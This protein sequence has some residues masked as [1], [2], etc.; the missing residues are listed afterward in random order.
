MRKNGVNRELRVIAGGVCAP[1][2]FKAGGIACGIKA[3]GDKDLALI[4]AER[5]CPTACV[6]TTSS[7]CGAPVTISKRHV[8]KGYARAV[9]AN[10]G[11]ANVFLENGEKI[12]DYACGLV[13]KH[14]GVLKE[15]V[16]I[17]STGEVG[18]SLSFE[19]FE[20][21]IKL[22]ATAL[23]T[24][25]ECGYTA[26]QAISNRREEAKQF[27]Y[28]F[29]IGDFTCKIGGIFKGSMH[30]SP[31]MATTLAFLTTDV[32][33]SPEM[34]QRALQAETKET[35]NQLDIDG[36][37]SP[38]DTVCIMANGKAGNCLIDCVDSEYK[39]FSFALR[40]VLTEICRSIASN[41]RSDRTLICKVSGAKSKQISRALTR[42][43]VGTDSIRKS[44][45]RGSFDVEG[46]LYLLAEKN[47]VADFSRVILSLRAEKGELVIFEDGKKLSDCGERVR[48]LLQAGEIEIVVELNEGNYGSFAFGCA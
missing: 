34:L 32:N 33:I 10:G 30:V 41:A 3:D 21:G 36:E 8:K 47:A 20:R 12:A 48:E 6:Y 25:E 17:A 39:K 35:L 23:G 38:N 22:L 2:G 14:F 16:V 4:L 1:E 44:I 5:R 40:S 9:L 18:K 27:S 45:T 11:V 43:I 28:S 24:T 15:E 19:P 26:A 46:V 29:D 7:K 37:P 13:E 31:N 42:E